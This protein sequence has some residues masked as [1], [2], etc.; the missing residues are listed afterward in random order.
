[1]GI[2]SVIQSIN[3]PLVEILT[4]KFRDSKNLDITYK[5][6]DSGSG[7]SNTT[8]ILN[9]IGATPNFTR[10]FS[11]EKSPKAH[12]ACQLYKN[13]ITLENGENT[14]A[15]KSFDANQ[16]IS[17]TSKEV[18]VNAQYSVKDQANLYFVSIA[19]TDYKNATLNLKFPVNDVVAV[20][21]KIEQKSKTLFKNIFSYQLHDH[22]MTATNFDRLFTDLSK[23]IDANDVL[24]VYIAGHGIT[25]DK[26]GLYYFY[27]YD[28]SDTS[29]NEL[30]KQAISV[31][32]I[33]SQLHKIQAQKSLILFDTCNS[34]SVLDNLDQKII[35]DRLSQDN[36]RNFIVA[37]SKG[38]AAI[39]G[40]NNHG[41]FSYA[42]LDAFDKAYF[43][44][45]TKLTPTT[46]AGYVESEV[47]RISQEIF[48]YEQT[49][50]KYLNGIGFDIGIK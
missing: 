6:C 41:V 49:P 4:N 17:S 3:P 36:S 2:R 32:N 44:N 38:Q 35:G 27:P 34:G 1:M 40:Y 42:V 8:L 39:D 7:I 48:H 33:K 43:G 16:T 15:I 5:V 12:E 31:N 19:V 46:L 23:K 24:I 18:T 26:D 13:T 11:I 30:A 10:G 21:K 45:Q 20:K 47:P 9:G 28:I 50:Q 22:E 37:S 29:P 25:S 14:I